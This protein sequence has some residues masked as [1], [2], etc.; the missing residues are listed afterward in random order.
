MDTES[1]TKVRYK[2]PKPIWLYNI[3]YMYYIL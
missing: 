3:K 2:P 1:F